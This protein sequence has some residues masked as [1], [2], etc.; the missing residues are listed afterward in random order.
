MSTDRIPGI[1][2]SHWQYDAGQTTGS[3]IADLITQGVQFII[4][5][6]SEGAFND[7]A[8]AYHKARLKEHPEIQKGAYHWPRVNATSMADQ[9]DFFI[10]SMN[11]NGDLDGWLAV[12]DLEEA[13]ADKFGEPRPSY[14]NCVVP[15]S[16]RFFQQVPGHDL[17]MYTRKTYWNSPSVGGGDVHALGL[18]LWSAVGI[19]QLLDGSTDSLVYL[20]A[21]DAYGAQLA[22]GYNNGVNP[23]SGNYAGFS[24]PNANV[25]VQFGGLHANQHTYDGD[26]FNGSLAALRLLAQTNNGP[27]QPVKVILPPLTLDFH[28]RV[29]TDAGAAP[30]GPVADPVQVTLPPLNFRLLQPMTGFQ[31]GS[32]VPPSSAVLTDSP[33]TS[34]AVIS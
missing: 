31:A 17:I 34:S 20:N 21:F 4:A 14:S 30:G 22:F 16:N 13:D 32:S 33:E 28:R 5:K 19:H 29:P 3:A 8:W 11:V 9:C 12:I 25:L 24:G 10:E 7:S 18:K 6:S 27:N 1:D 15:F 26:C 23:Y 2:I